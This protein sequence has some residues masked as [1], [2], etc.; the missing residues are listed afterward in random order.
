MAKITIAGRPN[1]GKS[2]LFNALT[3]T[4]DA[5]VHDRPGVTRDTIGGTV[6]GH[7]EYQ[8]FDTA[9]LE[10][11]RDGIAA[12]STN[13]AMD[14]ISD[15]DAILFVVDGRAG[16]LAEDMSWAR[17]VRRK[18]RAPILL[19]I[20]KAESSKR[21]S[22]VHEFYKLGFGDPV[23]ISAEHKAGFDEIFEFLEKNIPDSK[24]ETTEP[25]RR[26][27]IAIL[28]QPNVGKSTLVNRVLGENRQ[29]VK[30][31]PG[32]TRD[33]VKIPTRFY[34]RDILLMDTAGLR[35]KSNVRDDVETLSALKSLDAI[36]KSDVVVLVVDATR[37]IENQ[38][39]GIAARVYDAGKI[40]CVALNKWD[41]IE[42]DE[43]DEKLLKLKHKFANSFHQII[44][45]M[46][47]AISAEKGTGV[48]NMFKRI[49][50][51]FD[52]AGATA[53]TSLINK[54][55]GE[56]VNLRQPPMSR[57]KRPMKIKFARQTG[58]HPMRITINVGGASDI[59][60]SYTRYLRR[61]IAT[62]LHL[63]H[64]P[65]TIEYEKSENPFES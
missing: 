14:A 25:D 2:T 24:T 52:I 50:E 16:L 17:A 43:R 34:G 31:L 38:A 3:G 60:E 8:L 63:E 35:R 32:V 30:D 53:P 56:L 27:K 36:E 6:S 47:L 12:D 13:M 64:L 55:V 5:L 39:L 65:I 33:T 7:P 23:M 62:A 49:Y 18:T 58:R 26:V 9:G 37:D 21:L 46:I 19:L 29:I 1:T 45:P 61:G 20:N 59:P 44:K 48:Q 4:R 40:L 15:A 51:Q 41:L 42:P 28:G 54:I 11:A 57:L 10:S 22:D